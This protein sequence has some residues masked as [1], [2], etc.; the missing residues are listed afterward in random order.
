MESNYKK[1]HPITHILFLA[2]SIVAII[3][4]II[5][6][7][8]GFFGYPFMF[9]G[10]VI[11]F[12]GGIGFYV[13][14][15]L[16][17]LEMVIDKFITIIENVQKPITTSLEYLKN[18]L[19][20]TMGAGNG[21]APFSNLN[22]MKVEIDENTPKEKIEELKNKF[23]FMKDILES[24]TKNMTKDLADMSLNQLKEELQAAIN[25][26]NFEKAAVIRDLISKK[27]NE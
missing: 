21:F 11:S 27:E 23:P 25:N 1:P 10:I 16:I 4:G 12:L 8:L 26:D 15:F 13:S 2:V 18:P 24:I 20:S 22:T 17:A 9:E 19:L 5:L 14:K 3:T 7:I 6:F